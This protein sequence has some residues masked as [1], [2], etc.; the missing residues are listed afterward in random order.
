VGSLG[1][2]ELDEVSFKK[3]LAGEHQQMP[4]RTAAVHE[5]QHR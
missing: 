1:L 5:G 4:V 2:I 3:K